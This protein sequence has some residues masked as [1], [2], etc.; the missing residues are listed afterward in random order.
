MARKAATLKVID[1]EQSEPKQKVNN[2]LKI[3]SLPLNHLCSPPLPNSYTVTPHGSA[4]K[5]HSLAAPISCCSLSAMA[6][7]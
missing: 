1:N 2:H 7:H 3:I 5:F 4:V 6:P